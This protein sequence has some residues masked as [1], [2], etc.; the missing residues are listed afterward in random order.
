VDIVLVTAGVACLIAAVAGV[1]I[2]AMNVE[3]GQ[4]A[5]LRRQFLLGL[6]GVVFLGAGIIVREGSGTPQPTPQPVTTTA[7][8]PPVTTTAPEAA[9]FKDDF[10]TPGTR[11][12][13]DDVDTE[14][15][16]G[17]YADETYRIVAKREMGR[18]GVLVSAQ[19]A[20]REDV[21]LTVDARRVG[22]TARSSYGYGLFCRADGRDTLYHFT[23]WAQHAVIAK[24]IDGQRTN[25][26]TTSDVTAATLND[27]DKRL[28]AVC[29][30]IQRGRAVRLEFWVDGKMILPA[31]DKNSPITS[32]GTFGMHVALLP[33][34]GNVGDTLEVEFDN[35][36]A[37][38]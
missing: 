2:K 18:R 36:K 7:P 6:L 10:S 24:S 21:D 20:P 35:F 17:Q 15:T 13:V 32:S 1:A 5:S 25:L 11:R 37:F 12:W 33:G 14:G 28:E 3:I 31:T 34:G 19:T 4:I 27:A 8:E 16:G 23:I 26:A 22:G 30:T 9:F 29:R 38:E